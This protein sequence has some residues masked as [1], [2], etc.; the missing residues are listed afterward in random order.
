[1]MYIAAR[2]TK[3]VGSFPIRSHR[4]PVTGNPSSLIQAN[5]LPAYP[6]RAPLQYDS[7]LSASAAQ[8]QTGHVIQDDTVE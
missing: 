1:M 3:P 7:L 6:T 5:A 4:P 8:T 2:E